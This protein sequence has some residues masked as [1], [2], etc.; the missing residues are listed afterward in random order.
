MDISTFMPLIEVLLGL[1]GAG[2]LGVVSWATAK[3]G[4]GK[5]TESSEK[6]NGL[7]NEAIDYGISFAVERLTNRGK[8]INSPVKQEDKDGFVD[9]A[10]EYVVKGATG[11]IQAFGLT[12]GRVREM[13]EARLGGK[14]EVEED[15]SSGASM[16]AP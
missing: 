2:L 13:V 9:D 10:V 8:T 5:K 14:I 15:Q 4:I 6:L 11:I 16:T 7:L 12:E 1:L 3:W